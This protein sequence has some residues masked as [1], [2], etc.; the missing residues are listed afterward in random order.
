MQQLALWQLS[1]PVRLRTAKIGVNQS[2]LT[3][4][5]RPLPVWGIRPILYTTWPTLQMNMNNNFITNIETFIIFQNFYCSVLI[6]YFSS[7][8]FNE[9]LILDILFSFVGVFLLLFSAG[10]VAELDPSG[11]QNN[12]EHC[13]INAQYLHCWC[14]LWR[15]TSAPGKSWRYEYKLW[16]EKRTGRSTRKIT[17]TW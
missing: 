1:S 7:L 11:G 13:S 15:A 8:F 5:V 10:C 4:T 6:L 16:L 17:E 2:Q 12:A 14:W 3:R 9:S